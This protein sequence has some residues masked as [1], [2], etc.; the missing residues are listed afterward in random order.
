MILDLEQSNFVSA[1]IAQWDLYFQCSF[2]DKLQLKEK[3][4]FNF[5]KPGVED[6][7][8]VSKWQKSNDSVPGLGVLLIW[9][10]YL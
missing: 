5:W 2:C 8:I 1:H 9:K 4:F 10:M 3:V 7:K 6:P